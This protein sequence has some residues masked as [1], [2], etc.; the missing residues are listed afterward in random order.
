MADEE[1]EASNYADDD[2]AW[3]ADEEEDD[4]GDPP[5]WVH[6]PTA[7]DLKGRWHQ[8]CRAVKA[9]ERMERDGPE[10]SASLVAARNARDRAEA[11]WRSALV[12]KPVAVR[13]GYAQKKMDR[14]QRAV[15][16]AQ[17]E[18]QQFEEEAAQRRE[19]LQS[20]V[21][22][23]ERRRQVRM[24][25]LDDLH[26]EAGALAEG[27]STRGQRGQPD[28]GDR[29][30]RS[31]VASEIQAFI[32][33]LEEGSE[34]RGRANL[35]L[36]KMANMPE[37]PNDAHYSICTDG[38]D[39]ADDG[40]PFQQVVRRGRGAQ[41]G[42][43][44]TAMETRGPTWSATAHGRWNRHRDNESDDHQ[45]PRMHRQAKEAV[46]GTSTDGRSGTGP[47]VATPTDAKPPHGSTPSPV[48]PPT[49]VATATAAKAHADAAQQATGTSRGGRTR[50][51]DSACDDGL[52]EPANKSHRGHDDVRTV[53]VE[54]GGDDAA[55]AAKLKQEQDAAIQA[56][57]AANARFGDDASIQI[58]GQLYAH[59]VELVRER[60][61]AAGVEPMAGGKQLLQ[62][63]PEELNAWIAQVLTPAEAEKEEAKQL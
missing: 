34:A 47:I 54:G 49:P 25:E 3:N 13:L 19:E 10:P 60:A 59:K 29:S 42:T 8:E 24:D 39:E 46:A 61:V 1:E 58:A 44:P 53:S 55:R 63:T 21:D 23:A 32:E 12:P 40:P 35:L 45:H 43:R 62:L 22:H 18:L 9:L 7:E 27:G 11:E 50:A 26:R 51:A 56:A 37:P 48:A 2:A 4:V 41:A 38:E 5:G 57:Q 16:K 6:Q 17:L 14:A 33:T 28:G 20:A 31:M 52:T 15:E 30:L 36:T